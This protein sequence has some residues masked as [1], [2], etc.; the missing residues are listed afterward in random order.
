[1]TAHE[2]ERGNLAIALAK[3]EHTPEWLTP[4]QIELLKTA[5][6]EVPEKLPV[7]EP[8][9]GLGRLARAASPCNPKFTEV[10]QEMIA[11]ALAKPKKPSK[12]KAA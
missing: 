2:L 9:R 7:I 11:K 3:L 5:G 8:A 4:E 10:G 1:M 12:R 6:V